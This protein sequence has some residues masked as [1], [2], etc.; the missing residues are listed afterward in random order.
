[1]MDIATS[2]ITCFAARAFSLATVLLLG[3]A[4]LGSGAVA[5]EFDAEKHFRGK[6]MS[7][8]VDFKPGGGTDTQARYF[9]KHFGEFLPGKP[10]IEVKNMVPDPA[11]RTYVWKAKPDGLTL[12]FLALPA[13]GMELTDSSLEIEAYKFKYI[14]S[15]AARDM[16]LFTR[17]DSVPY[18]SL[19]EA[20]KGNVK[21]VFSERV[22]SPAELDG[23][24]LGI[25][26]GLHYLGV[27]FQILPVAQ[28]G[29]N[30]NFVMLE[31]GEINSMMVGSQWYFMPNR[32][33]GW[34]AN[35]YVR[36]LAD[37]GHPADKIGPNAEYKEAVPHIYDMLTKEQQ[38]VWDGLILPDVMAGKSLATGPQVPDNIVKVLRD[39]YAKAMKDPEFSAGFAKLQGQPVD[40]VTGEKL[41]ARAL[42]VHNAYKNELPGLRKVQEELYGLYVKGR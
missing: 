42:E 27:P 10:R 29:T 18:K 31:R 17:G 24:V 20:I 7:L 15:H 38:K 19:K 21:L 5:A 9:A 2:R 22:G 3:A 40:L 23:R 6:T 13:I 25:A 34:L 11:G 8:I 12:S 26:L 41:Q 1:M 36:P 32:R 37:F 35:G 28:A 14:G 39:S 30:D 4:A 33:K 16:V